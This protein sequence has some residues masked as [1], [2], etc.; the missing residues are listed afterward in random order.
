[1]HQAELDLAHAGPAELRAEVRCPE[2]PLLH[3]GLERGRDPVE[4]LLRE[5]MREG[6]DRE[7]L[8]IDELTD[9]VEGLL[10]NPMLFDS[11]PL[12]ELN[13]GVMATPVTTTKVSARARLN[14]FGVR[15][16]LPG[17]LCVR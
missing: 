5:L 1:M 4:L 9:P 11:G 8:A 2:S 3:L 6:F 12:Q 10:S 13:P 15:V 7:D 16:R 17:I 14:S